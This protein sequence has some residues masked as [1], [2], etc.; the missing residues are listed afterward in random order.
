MMKLRC[1]SGG[2]YEKAKKKE[3]VQLKKRGKWIK[4]GDYDG[5]QKPLPE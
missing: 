1:Q 5:D 2:H 3:K 4:L